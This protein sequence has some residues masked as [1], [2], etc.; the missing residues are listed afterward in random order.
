MADR[1]IVYFRVVNRRDKRAI[2]KHSYYYPRV[3]RMFIIKLYRKMLGD[4]TVTIKSIGTFV[5]P[6]RYLY[7]GYKID[8]RRTPA[9]RGTG[10]NAERRTRLNIPQR[11]FTDDTIIDW[12]RFVFIELRSSANYPFL[13]INIPDRVQSLTS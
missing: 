8:G 13:I 2:F 9:I 4:I 6:I 7:V 12:K 5:N 3:W 1:R 11:Q 10:N